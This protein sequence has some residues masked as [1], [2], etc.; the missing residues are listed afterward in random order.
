MI[1]ESS[2]RKA[3]GFPYHA[4]CCL[5]QDEGK[6]MTRLFGMEP[7]ELGYTLQH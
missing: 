7:L 3:I 4:F 5:D 2:A 6:W 1:V